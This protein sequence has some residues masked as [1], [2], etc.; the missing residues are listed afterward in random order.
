MLVIRE[1]QMQALSAA[2]R[3]RFADVAEQW[4]WQNFAHQCESIGRAEVRDRVDTMMQRAQDYGLG[5]SAD[6]LAYL[7][8]MF[9]LGPRFDVD[10]DPPWPGEILRSS[11]I[12]ADRKMELLA[13]RHRAEQLERQP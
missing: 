7:E 5:S 4:A 8:F 12:P 3:A 1:A 2:M 9:V 11:R 6:H 10:Q 13:K